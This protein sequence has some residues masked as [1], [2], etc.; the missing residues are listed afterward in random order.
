MGPREEQEKPTF[1]SEEIAQ[2]EPEVTTP[3]STISSSTLSGN[4]QWVSLLKTLETVVDL[5]C[6]AVAWM[7]V[8]V[9]YVRT[10]LKKGIPRGI[11]FV[12]RLKLI[13]SHECMCGRI[14]SSLE[15]PTFGV[16]PLTLEDC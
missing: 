1:V 4:S 9:L 7:H 6:L 16:T 12:L 8:E 3:A 11:W 5:L 13:K 10:A 15:V 2:D 14:S